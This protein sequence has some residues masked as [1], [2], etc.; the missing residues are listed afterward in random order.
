MKSNREKQ[1]FQ[2]KNPWDPMKKK[3]LLFLWILFLALSLSGCI[4]IVEAP[5]E[6]PVEENGEPSEENGEDEGEDEG[7]E[8][9]EEETGEDPSEDPL[10]EPPREPVEISPP[11]ETQPDPGS[12]ELK[13][14]EE[15][16]ELTGV[17]ENFP[18]G[19]DVLKEN[20]LTSDE[21]IRYF[22]EKYGHYGGSFT[23]QVSVGPDTYEQDGTLYHQKEVFYTLTRKEDNRV[24]GKE[25]LRQVFREVSLNPTIM[26]SLDGE[27]SRVVESDAVLSEIEERV[28][29]RLNDARSQE[30]LSAL[31]TASDLTRLARIKS[32][33]MG[34]YN[35][36]NHESPT[37]GSP[38]DMAAALG[39]QLRSEN[40]QW[41]TWELTSEEIH[42]NF[43]NSPGHRDN[44]MTPG[45]TEVG[46]GII[47]L[48][49][50]Y[51]VTELFR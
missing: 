12:G 15:P 41:A 29:G 35:Y 31:S 30:G 48:E 49:N 28:I 17:D 46:V 39:V 27:Y 2:G 14:P 51:Y 10:E 6:E 7:E 20:T 34:L 11:V 13:T 24:I 8:E 43:M 22:E 32:M 19:A 25:V 21:V 4:W 45:F 38:F 5:G 47:K 23:I 36:F 16:V 26:D 42:D 1:R 33:D 40:I 9:A 44:R 50:G 3:V 37:Y 18:P